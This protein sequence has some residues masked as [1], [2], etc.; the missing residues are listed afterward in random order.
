MKM[1][2]IIIEVL[3][4]NYIVVIA[5]TKRFGKN[6][7]MFEGNTF[8]QC[9]EYIRRELGLME[10]QGLRLRSMLIYEPY[11]DRNGKTLPC[12]IHIEGGS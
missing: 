11:T 6:E 12:Y 4:D 2:N 5:T 3:D 10:K 1:E 9:F 7:I 8:D